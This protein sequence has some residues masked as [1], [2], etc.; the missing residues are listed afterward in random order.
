MWTR[1]VGNLGSISS[2]LNARVFRP[3]II[4]AAF[5][6]VC[7]YVKKAAKTT[8]EQKTRVFNVDEIDTWVGIHKLLTQIC[9]IFHNFKLLL[10]SNYPLKIRSLCFIQ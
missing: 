5:F 4:S 3:N 7:M 2:T 6:Y 9:N 8:F 1:K 10:Q